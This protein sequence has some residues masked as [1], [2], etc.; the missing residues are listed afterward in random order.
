MTIWDWLIVGYMFSATITF[1]PTI[2]AIFITQSLHD[3]GVSFN[4]CSNF[5]EINKERL[6]NHYSRIQGTLRFWKT[7]AVKNGRF[8]YYCLWWSIISS[9]SMP[10]LSQAI[11]P[12]QTSSKWLLTVISA[13]TALCLGFHKGLKV[14]ENYRAF[15]HGESE[16]YDVYR[17]FLDLPQKF[18]N[19]EEEQITHYFEQVE[20]IRRLIRNAE[21]DNLPNIDDMKTHQK[22]VDTR[23]I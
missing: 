17:R 11:D 10:F 16:F 7:E 6:N 22:G 19:T 13:H 8:H 9:V 14:A 20:A 4:G 1:V 5:S 23:N 2:F 3:G 21:T 15:R 12:N 18:G